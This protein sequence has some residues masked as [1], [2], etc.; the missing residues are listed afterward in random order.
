M[1]GRLKAITSLV[2]QITFSLKPFSF[3]PAG[4]FHPNTSRHTSPAMCPMKESKDDNKAINWGPPWKEARREAVGP[5]EDSN[6]LGDSLAEVGALSPSNRLYY[7]RS[8]IGTSRNGSAS[9]ALLS[10]FIF[11]SCLFKLSSPLRTNFC[12]PPKP[13][14]VC[15]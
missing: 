8:I 6:Q 9:T 2:L 4:H 12:K 1:R 3:C 7:R 13:S 5:L 14:T 15:R 10:P 11:S